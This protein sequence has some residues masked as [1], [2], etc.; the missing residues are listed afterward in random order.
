[1]LKFNNDSEPA[2]DPAGSIPNSTSIAPRK[3]KWVIDDAVRADLAHAEETANAIVR[4][5]D[6]LV[7][8]FDGYGSDCMK[9]VGTFQY[10]KQSYKICVDF[11]SYF[12]LFSFFRICFSICV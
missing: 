7:L 8:I 10:T 1:L 12:W 3:L 4:D 6:P 11:G 2:K 5:S 9:T